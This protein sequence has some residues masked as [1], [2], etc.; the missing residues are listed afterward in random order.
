MSLTSNL[1]KAARISNNLKA[2]SQGPTSYA[3][4]YARRK[5]YAK[6]MGATHRFLKAFG[7]SK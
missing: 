3:K 2:A 6:S 7:L 4:R 5:I 1:Y